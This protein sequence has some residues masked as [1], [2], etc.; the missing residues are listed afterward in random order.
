MSNVSVVF[1]CSVCSSANP[2]SVFTHVCLSLLPRDWDTS[3]ETL[4]RR[5]AEGEINKCLNDLRTSSV[6]SHIGRKAK[7]SFQTALCHG[8]QKRTWPGQYGVSI[9]TQGFFFYNLDHVARS[10]TWLIYFWGHPLHPPFIFFCHLPHPALSSSSSSSSLPT[11]PIVQQP[12]KPYGE[13][14]SW[15]QSKPEM[16]SDGEF[17]C[18]KPIWSHSAVAYGTALYATLLHY[19]PEGG[20]S[21][22]FGFHARPCA[23]RL[24][25]G[26]LGNILFMY[27]GHKRKKAERRDAF[28]CLLSSAAHSWS[29]FQ[30][31]SVWESTA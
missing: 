22:M 10:C 2:M 16:V 1:T 18:T 5:Q 17:H 27:S 12:L 30:S 21:H 31:H 11:Q 25:P 15:L 9:N 14:Y 23:F 4:Q 26:R 13:I 24:L 28:A 7:K 19:R 3:G 20:W 29:G 6:W 8:R